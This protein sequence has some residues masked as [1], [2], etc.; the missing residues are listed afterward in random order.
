[1]TRKMSEIYVAAL[2]IAHEAKT[3]TY[4]LTQEFAKTTE[5]QR[6]CDAISKRLVDRIMARPTRCVAEIGKRHGLATQANNSE[7]EC[8]KRFESDLEVVRK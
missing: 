7:V 6:L 3:N 1:M 8:T 5:Y 4:H 2:N